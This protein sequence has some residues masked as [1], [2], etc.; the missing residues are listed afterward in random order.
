MTKS[1]INKF[2]NHASIAMIKSKGK[3]DQWFSFGVVKCGDVL[4]NK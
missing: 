1:Q 3:T 2:R 4:K